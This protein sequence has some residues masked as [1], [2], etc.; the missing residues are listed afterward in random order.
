FMVELPVRS[1]STVPA[2]SLT[3]IAPA[4]STRSEEHTS[5]LQ[6]LTNLVCRLLLEKKKKTHHSEDN[7]PDGYF[8]EKLQATPTARAYFPKIVQDSAQH[9]SLQYK[10]YT[11]TYAHSDPTTK[12]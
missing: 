2:E 10:H 8:Q 7:Q 1:V 4:Q 11:T 6:S 9:L 5:E 3:G 12:H